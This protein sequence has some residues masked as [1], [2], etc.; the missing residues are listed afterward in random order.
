MTGKAGKNMV[1]DVTGRVIANYLKDS[2]GFTTTHVYYR[3]M[4]ANNGLTPI[5]HYSITAYLNKAR[6]Q[7]FNATVY[8]NNDV[9][10]TSDPII[11]RM[12]VTV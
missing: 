4:H 7:Q 3:G 11:T 10:E 12:E 1:N 6:I 5:I 9:P 2:L 8:W